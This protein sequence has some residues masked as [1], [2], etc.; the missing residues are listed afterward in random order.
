MSVDF[1]RIYLDKPITVNR[2]AQS[3]LCFVD[4]KILSKG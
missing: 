3:A 2:S 4:G 1:N